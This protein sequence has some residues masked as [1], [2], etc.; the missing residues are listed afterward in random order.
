MESKDPF[1]NPVF[2]YI[3]KGDVQANFGIVIFSLSV[4]FIGHCCTIDQ[5][6]FYIRVW[7]SFGNWKF[8]HVFGVIL[9][10]TISNW[11]AQNRLAVS[12][13]E[14]RYFTILFQEFFPSPNRMEFFSEILVRWSFHSINQIRG[15]RKFFSH[16]ALP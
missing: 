1:W 9:A 4:R 16:A 2:Y 11:K 15:F 14:E 13:F 5:N 12:I 6:F 3:E 8:T 10:C 7:H